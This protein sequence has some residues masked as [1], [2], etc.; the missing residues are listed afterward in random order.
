MKL[1]NKE[2]LSIKASDIVKV[3][4]TIE[5]LIDSEI[6]SYKNKKLMKIKKLNDEEIK[7]IYDKPF[8]SIVE[9]L[10]GLREEIQDILWIDQ[11]GDD[12]K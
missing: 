10:E 4:Q 11:L 5:N 7:N 3:R 2:F 9:L 12:L 6:N 1:D 8:E